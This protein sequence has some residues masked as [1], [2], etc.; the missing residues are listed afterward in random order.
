MPGKSTI[1]VGSDGELAASDVEAAL[2]KKT[3]HGKGTL[4]QPIKIQADYVEAGEMRHASDNYVLA[5]RW[6]GGGL[7][8]GHSLR[9]TGLSRG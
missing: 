3:D 5:Y 7:F 2:G 4:R 1:E 8:G 6:E 9:L